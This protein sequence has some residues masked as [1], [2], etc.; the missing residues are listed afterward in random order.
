MSFG[1]LRTIRVP[2]LLVAAFLASSGLSCLF[3]PVDLGSHADFPA[4]FQLVWQT[5]DRFHPGFAFSGLDWE[6]ARD[7]YAPMM[8]TVSTQIGA[9]QI[10]AEMFGLMEDETISFFQ[11]KTGEHIFSFVEEIDYNFDLDVLW[12]YLEPQGFEFFQP[13]VAYWGG[14]MFDSVAYVRIPEWDF[15]LS[16]ILLDEFLAKHDYATAAIIDVRMNEGV[17]G[18]DF[19]MAEIARRFNDEN[20]LGCYAVARSGPSHEDLTYVPH[21][22]RSRSD[23][24]DRPVAVLIGEYSGWVTEEFALMADVLPNA[25]LMGDTTRGQVGEARYWP[26]PGT[27]EYMLPDSTL[28]RADSTCVQGIGVA[29]DIF[30]DAGP[31]DFAAGIDPVLDYA[32]DWAGS[33]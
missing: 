10:M 13:G 5:A 17:G 29:P 32:L 25:V 7:E 15:Y 18:Y 4:E 6:A 1:L 27:W 30:V 23:W 20:R 14:C 12:G 16:P 2:L 9:M 26:L 19:R 8:D 11:L 21:V 33:Q 28:L 3:D 31:D 22:V 24:F